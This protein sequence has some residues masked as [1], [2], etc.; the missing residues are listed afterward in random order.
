MKIQRLLLKNFK[1]YKKLELPLNDKEEFPEG[2]IIVQG[3][4]KE[5][6]N[7]F[8]KTSLMEA[9]LVGLFGLEVS[10]AAKLN[11]NDLITF[12]EK[13]AEIRLYFSLD[14]Q[15]YLIIQTY[16][17]G[18]RSGSSSTKYFQKV[19]NDYKENSGLDIFELLQITWDQ[20][21]GTVYVMQGEIESLVKAEPAELRKLIIK[22]FRLDLTEA[23]QK[24]L[25]QKMKD[26][27]QEVKEIRK[28]YREPK[29][30]EE[31]IEKEQEE[32]SKE[33]DILKNIEEEIGNLKEEIKKYPE[34]ESISKINSLNSEFKNNNSQLDILQIDIDSVLNEYQ[35]TEEDIDTNIDKIPS[36]IE[37]LQNEIRTINE[38]KEAIMQE[39]TGIETRIKI[40]ENSMK[41]VKD[42]I[43]F[44]KG[45]E[46]A[47]CPTCQRDISNIEKAEI[48]QHFQLEIDELKVKMPEIDI[49]AYDVT[50]YQEEITEFKLQL[51]KLNSIKAKIIDKEKLKERNKGIQD[52]IQREINIFNFQTIEELLT[53]YKMENLMDLKSKVSILQT[54]INSKGTNSSEVQGRIEKIE[55]KIGEL[56]DKLNQM[57]EYEKRLNEL[58]ILITHADKCKSLIKSF[59]TE[60]MVEKR[61]IKNINYV[62]SDLIKYFTGGQYDSISLVSGGKQGTSLNISVHDTYNDREKEKKFLSGGDKAAIGFALR[63]GISELMRIIRPTKDSPAQNPRVDFLILDEPFGT[64]DTSRREEILKTLQIQKKFNQIFLITH[65]AIPDDVNSHFIKISKNMETGLSSAELLINPKLI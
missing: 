31:E 48:L 28:K 64:L 55:N 11:I 58:E 40:T 65:T 4:T 24:H 19:G 63:F 57:K 6:S 33:K 53:L 45:E 27:D 41:K 14:S 59:V 18:T 32:L 38:Q 50:Q 12:G 42:S 2:L 5:R 49:N 21:K 36:K 9:I 30:I 17:R 37:N 56:N 35:I 13:S 61:L 54:E 39:R 16:K 26:A 10:K 44:N 60:Y 25:D 47:K 7:S 46:I 62:T 15:E 43:K 23:A 1:C 34:I 8:G 52:D 29:D 22:L 51:S 3:N 20:A